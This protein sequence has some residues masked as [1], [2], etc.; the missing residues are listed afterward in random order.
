MIY[1]EF[2]E[3]KIVLATDSGFDV[4]PNKV[5]KALKSHHRDAGVWALKAGRRALFVFSGKWGM[6]QMNILS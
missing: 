6:S 1:K 2:L 3:T 4:D 5:N